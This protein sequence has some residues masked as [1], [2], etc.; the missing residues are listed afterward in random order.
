MVHKQIGMLFA[1]FMGLEILK[2][3]GWQIVDLF[4]PL[5]LVFQQAFEAANHS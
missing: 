1:L 2:W 3:D 4:F 5:E